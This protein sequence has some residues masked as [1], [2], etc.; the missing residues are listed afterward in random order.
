MFFRHLKTLTWFSKEAFQLTGRSAKLQ[1]PPLSPPF[2]LT[3]YR[4]NNTYVRVTPTELVGKK[5]A[6]SAPTASGQGQRPFLVKVLTMLRSRP[7]RS[8][9]SGPARDPAGSEHLGHGSQPA[10]WPGV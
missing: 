1:R 6:A 7:R 8:H 10:T 5:S 9:L 4:T 3:P 2:P